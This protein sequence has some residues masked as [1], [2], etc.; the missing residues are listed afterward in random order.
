MEASD[1]GAVSPGMGGKPAA[2]PALGLAAVPEDEEYRSLMCEAKVE[3]VAE[4]GRG[5]GATTG[6]ILLMLSR[7]QKIRII[8]SLF[9]CRHLCNKMTVST[10][11]T[12]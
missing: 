8:R 6:G 4:G 11:F 10:P 5:M 7:K 3:A 9:P 2:N 12:K 1:E